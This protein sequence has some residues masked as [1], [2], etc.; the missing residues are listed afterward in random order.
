MKEK[1]AARAD[2]ATAA[3]SIQIINIGSWI[4]NNSL[5]VMNPITGALGTRSIPTQL[6]S[7][8]GSAW[9]VLPDDVLGQ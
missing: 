4:Q 9:N 7:E 1:N 6:A 5:R 3:L 8:F 2:Y